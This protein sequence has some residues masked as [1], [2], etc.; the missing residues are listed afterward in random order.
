MNTPEIVVNIWFIVDIGTN[1]CYTWSIKPYA[2]I[3]TD[4]EKLK[5]LEILA[6]SDYITVH[7]RKLPNYYTLELGNEKL[8]GVVDANQIL[9]IFSGNVDYFISEIEKD[10]AEISNTFSNTM[11]NIEL[12]LPNNPMHVSTIIAENDKGETRTLTSEANKK[13]F[14]EEYL[15]MLGIKI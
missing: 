5:I 14:Q 6:Q 10:L 7:Q 9:N 8:A 3:G 12:K 4:D 15:R 13:W 2:L 11:Q 1:L